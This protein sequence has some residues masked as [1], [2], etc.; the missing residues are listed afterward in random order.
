MKLTR[1][2]F[3]K[4]SG[5]A[6]GALGLSL[7]TF[8]FEEWSA[9]A[10][11][12]EVEKLP[13]QCNTCGTQC[14][15]WAYVK[16]GRVWKVEGHEEHARSLG[17]L[18]A[19]SHGGLGWVYD[20][21]RVQQPLKRVGE[22]EFEPIS[23]EQALTE[24]ADKLD[25]ILTEYGPGYVAY[26]H[27]P[28][29]TGTFY[30]ERLMHAL[31]VSTLCTHATS[32]NAA[33]NTGFLYS[34]GGVPDADLSNTEYALIIGRNHGGGIRTDQ[35]KKMSEALSGDAKIVC[36][37]PRQ[38]NIARIADDW[39]PIKPGTDLAMVLAI[40]NVIIEEGLYDEEYVEEHAVGFDQFAERVERVTPDWAEQVTD[41]PAEKIKE[42]A[43]ELGENRPRSLVHPSWGGAFGAKYANSEETAR[44]VACVNAL[45]GNIN[46]EG[47]LIFHPTPELGSLNEDQYPAPEEP[48]TRRADGV[49]VM[50]EYPLAGDFGLPHYLMEKAQ[51]GELKSMFIRHHNPV[52]NFPDYEHMAE[53]F[54]NL[55]L[56]VVFEINMT[57]T[58]MLADYVLPECSF[59]EREEVIEASGGPY[60]SIS[61]RTQVIPK[62]YE[63]TKSFDEIIVELAEKL[64]VGEYFNFTL[65]EVNRARLEPYDITLEEFKE[66]GS[67]LIDMEAPL[68]DKDLNTRSGDFEF[69]SEVYDHVGRPGVVGWQPPAIGVDLE[70]D[71]FRFATG[72]EGF[73]SH[74]ATAN[75]ESLAQIT[76]DYDTNRL[77]IN[78][79]VA[80]ERGI[81]DGDKV[82]VKSPVSTE[83]VRV[84]VTELIHPG[85]VFMPSGYGNKTPFYETAEEIATLNPN[86]IVPYQTSDIAGHSMRQETTVKI[87]KV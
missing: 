33:R 86:D 43:L 27:Y 15:A 2:S 64:G 70:E 77:W 81:E 63:E 87:E 66:K 82:K 20:A 44:A 31:G 76:K 30:S 36:V 24:I 41:V 59:M 10:Q 55:D 57:E 18:C 23:W 25:D 37:D 35:M 17:K 8:D 75:I 32:C 69:Y 78:S 51:E 21:D 52:R 73:H 5:L 39:V 14:G 1:R 80:E 85:T 65:D 38:N 26:G 29:S 54:R 16:N 45:L 60:A 72:K 22:K 4:K 13:T 34:M 42:M 83:E 49:G 71:E 7:Q 48:D 3:L 46:E 28:R 12:A 6:A 40:S 53:G 79:S 9:Q 62:V 68:G 84:K 58:A 61:M 19:R 74:T 56:S 50:D 47:G 11:E 67:M